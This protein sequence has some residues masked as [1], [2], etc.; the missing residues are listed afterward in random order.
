MLSDHKG[1]KLEVNNRKR[2]KN[3]QNTWKLNNTFLN[4]TWVKEEISKEIKK[5]FELNEKNT[6]SPNLCDAAK[7]HIFRVYISH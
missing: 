4:N 7:R 1:T 3:Y 5:Y 2:A 6:I